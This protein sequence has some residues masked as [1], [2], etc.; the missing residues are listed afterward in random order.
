MSIPMTTSLFSAD[1]RKRTLDRIDDPLAM[2]DRQ[3]DFAAIADKVQA[4]L[5]VPGKPS[6][7]PGH[8]RA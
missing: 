5:S 3:V 8:G 4:L 7:I 2:L 1:E 6:P